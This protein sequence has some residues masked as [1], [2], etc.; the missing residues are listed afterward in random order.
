M[1]VAVQNNSQM[2]RV[3][4]NINDAYHKIGQVCSF[5]YPGVANGAAAL[6]FVK[7]LNVG[8]IV[9]ITEQSTHP[10]CSTIKAVIKIV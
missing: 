5:G 3:E 6:S 9:N 7:K 1:G 2:V 10:Q 4:V 8:D